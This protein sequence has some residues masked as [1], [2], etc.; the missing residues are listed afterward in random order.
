M[1]RS[2]AVASLVLLAGCASTV[3][4][5]WRDWGNVDL[6]GRAAPPLDQ[7]VWL[8]PPDDLDS[9]RPAP[10]GWTPQPAP[11]LLVVFLQPH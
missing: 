4:S 2:F 8:L 9:A 11:W 7:G 6:A 10:D 5:V 1:L 3:R